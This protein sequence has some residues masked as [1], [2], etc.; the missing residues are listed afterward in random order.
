VANDSVTLFL[1]GSP[2]LDDYVQALSGLRGLLNA[3]SQEVLKGTQIEWRIDALE[4]SSALASFRGET[5]DVALVEQAADVYLGVG[6]A[7]KAG[8]SVAPPYRRSVKMIRDVLT[9]RVPSVRFE[10]AQDDVTVSL[11]QQAQVIPFPQREPEAQFGAVEGRIQTLSRRG[12]LRFILFDLVHDKAVTCYL[13]P[14]QEGLML[15]VW[16]RLAIVEGVVKRDPVSG[17]PTTVRHVTDVVL[18]PE[19][20]RGEWRSARG[21]QP[22]DEASE[23][24]IRRIRDAQ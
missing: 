1:E 2:T 6:R 14:D 12:S 9:D 19:R 22:S 17:R 24:R 15:D 5:A 18:T 16:G 7:L 20:E 11:A 21:V 3:I 4:A 13:A 8:E 10:T 23:T